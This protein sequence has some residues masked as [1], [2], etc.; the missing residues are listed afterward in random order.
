MNFRKAFLVIVISLVLVFGSACNLVPSHFEIETTSELGPNTLDR[1]DDL[2]DTIATGVEIGPETRAIIEQLNQTIADGLE[3]GFKPE[4]LSR[5]DVLL[6]IVEQGVGIKLGLDAETNMTVNNLI[7]TIDDAPDQWEDTMT[8]IIHTLEG[9]TSNV[10]SHLADEV[11][12]LMSEARINTQYVSASVG[13]EFRCNV[14]FLSAKAGDTV[15]QFIGRTLIGRLKSI[16]SGEEAPDEKI[17]TPWVCQIIPDQI[18]L[19][20]IGEEAVFET[21]VIK[22]SGY[23]FVEEN[24]P[25]AYIVDEAGQLVESVQL[26]PFISSPYQLQLNLQDID[27]STVPSRSRVVFEWP[28]EGTFY[29]LA[30]VLPSDEPEPTVEVQ[31]ELTINTA[32]LDIKKGPSDKYFTI[33]I[34]VQGATY[35]VTGH[36][37]DETWWQIDFDNDPCWVPASA[38]TR[39]QEPVGPALSIP[40]DPPAAAFSMSPDSGTAPIEIHF[41]D[42]STGNP[43][44]MF[45]QLIS[46]EGIPDTMG[47]NP[48]F[49]YEFTSGGTYTMQLRVSNEWG[50]DLVEQEIVVE[51]PTIIFVPMPLKPLIPFFAPTAT[52]DYSKRFVFRNFTNIKAGEPY[53]TNIPTA[54]YNCSVISLA[55]LHGDIEEG[56]TG[57]AIK[58]WLSAG[59]QYWTITPN[60]RTHRHGDGGQEKWSIGLMCADKVHSRFFSDIYIKPETNMTVTLNPAI[61]DI[62]ENYTCVISGYDVRNTDIQENSA[63]DII[64]VFTRKNSDGEWQVTADFRDH[65]GDESW[66]VQMMC[67]YDNQSV[68]MNYDDAVVSSIP[69]FSQE[70]GGYQT[71]IDSNNYACGIVGMSALSGDINEDH[72]GNIIQVYTY[73]KNNKWNI[74]ADFRSHN[75]DEIWDI[76]LMCIHRSVVDI[77]MNQWTNDWVHR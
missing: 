55:A 58:I 28:A 1:I 11:A 44:S 54:H 21:A 43:T 14:D 64:K 52:P 72:I 36:N 60:F 25:D 7:D 51:A 75:Q 17:P 34:A 18:D 38:V 10:A 47:S 63:G 70:T 73:Y 76:D 20:E 39:N 13:A 16:F 27:F 22:L 4:T 68:I 37:G 19:I 35:L 69:P 30:M 67:F 3:F 49:N 32:T 9:S 74:Y 46:E 48:D 23:N 5:I 40:F 24:K 45:W 41:W 66:I 8:E 56:G 62:P 2:N 12:G 29:A 59:G 50:E 71:T 15:D 31:P 33:G 57:N 77:Q 42:Q 6:G 53:A 65:G 26:Y 61:Y